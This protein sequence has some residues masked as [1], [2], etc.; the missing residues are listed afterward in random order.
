MEPD[1][2]QAYQSL[3]FILPQDEKRNYQDDPVAYASRFWTSKDPRYLTPYNERKL[4]HYFRL[5]YAD[6]LYGSPGLDMRGWET[7]RGRILVRYG[8]P[9]SDVVI[10]PQQDGIYSARQ[11]L[12][13]GRGRHR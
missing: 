1:E 13:G 3:D 12:V 7:Q 4:A 9:R 5:T 6:L 2:V 11:T 8:P 10:V